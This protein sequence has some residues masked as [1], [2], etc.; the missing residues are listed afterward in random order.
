MWVDGR[1]LMR[2]LTD[3]DW[4]RWIYRSNFAWEGPH[5]Q[6]LSFPKG[7]ASCPFDQ[8]RERWAITT[9]GP[10]S[11]GGGPSGS[12]EGSRCGWRAGHEEGDDLLLR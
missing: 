12:G 5:L 10:R 11:C 6:R 7:F 8:G 3:A 4:G 1:G 9:G 2:H